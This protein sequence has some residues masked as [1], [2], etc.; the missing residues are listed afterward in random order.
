MERYCTVY[1]GF[2]LCRVA[3]SFTPQGLWYATRVRGGVHAPRQYAIQALY[4]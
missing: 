1:M 3:E 2:E 4:N